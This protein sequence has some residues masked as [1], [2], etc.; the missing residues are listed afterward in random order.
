MNTLKKLIASLLFATISTS[1]FAVTNAQVFAYAAA[2]YPSFFPGT[3]TAGQFQQYDFRY[4]PSSKNYL[5]VDSS[6]TIFVMGPVTGGEIKSVGAVS[7]YAGAI[8]AWEASQ[9]DAGSDSTGSST[10]NQFAAP[11]SGTA[12]VTS[13]NTNSS[14]RTSNWTANI[15]SYGR[16]SGSVTDNCGSTLSLV[17]TVDSNGTTN[18]GYTNSNVCSFSGQFSVNRPREAL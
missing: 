11:W 4:Y 2:N 7:A 13:S 12:T 6:G 16:L 15:D 3:A 9:G 17:G 8:A 18:F 10:T 1:V 14:C 5:A